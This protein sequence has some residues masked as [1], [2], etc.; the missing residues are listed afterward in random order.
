MEVE[1]RCESTFGQTSI[2][3]DAGTYSPLRY[4]GNTRGD[5]DQT[6]FEGCVSLA[7]AMTMKPDPRVSAFAPVP[8]FGRN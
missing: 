3:T 1:T 7:N 4:P 8:V 2:K 5:L 6:S